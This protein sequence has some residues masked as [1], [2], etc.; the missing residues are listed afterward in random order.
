VF[1]ELL[2]PGY[3]VGPVYMS[4]AHEHDVEWQVLTFHV[5]APD[6]QPLVL[7]SEKVPARDDINELAK[8]AAS[9]FAEGLLKN[10]P[11]PAGN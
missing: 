5:T 4:Y 9:R 3:T 8:R 10:E 6:G 11:P 2:P 1:S 7:T